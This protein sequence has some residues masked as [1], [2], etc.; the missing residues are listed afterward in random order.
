M[1][2][3]IEATGNG[4]RTTIDENN[5]MVVRGRERVVLDLSKMS[6][7]EMVDLKYELAET[8]LRLKSKVV[9]SEAILKLT[10]VVLKRDPA[11]RRLV[12]AKNKTAMKY[13]FLCEYIGKIKRIE[14]EKAHDERQDTME[15]SIIKAV[16]ELTDEETWNVIM[17][18]AREIFDRFD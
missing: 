13:Q 3:K 18:R 4:V 2:E 14:K 5:F 6:I 16:K 8:L 11:H 15:R 1:I 10:R 17:N 12:Y 7:D 9:D